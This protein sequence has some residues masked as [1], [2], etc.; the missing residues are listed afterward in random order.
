M[1]LVFISSVTA[2]TP[3]RTISVMTGSTLCPAS[4]AAALLLADTPRVLAL[5]LGAPIAPPAAHA[6][7]Q[8]AVRIDPEPVAGPEHGRG[9]VFLDERGTV[10]AVACEEEG[11]II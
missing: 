7:V 8:V 4:P 1:R 9:R 2:M 10:D 11:A 3:L 6:D 5:L